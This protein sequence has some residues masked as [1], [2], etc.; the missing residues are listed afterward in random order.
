MHCLVL[1]LSNILL[2]CHQNVPDC[3]STCL[4]L[5]FIRN[6]LK[7]LML[8]D[9]QFTSSSSYLLGKLVVSRRRGRLSLGLEV[10]SLVQP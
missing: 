8:F 5:E 10:D 9:L 3:T 4:F 7:L 1:A 2:Y 6:R